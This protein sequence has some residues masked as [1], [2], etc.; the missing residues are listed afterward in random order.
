MNNITVTDDKCPSI[1][2]V[3]GDNNSN[4][5]LDKTESWIYKCQT[6]VQLSTASTATAKGS[7]NSLTALAFAF[8]N[9]LV[10]V[11]SLPNT[12]LGLQGITFSWL[13]VLLVLAVVILSVWLYRVLK[14]NKK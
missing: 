1:S 11:P 8:T 2:Y 5:L 12:G 4:S 13:T 3:S 10:D 6:N 7:A 14:K 9:V